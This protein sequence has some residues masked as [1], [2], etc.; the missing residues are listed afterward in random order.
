M[1]NLTN[2]TSEELA[3]EILIGERFFRFIKLSDDKLKEH[4]PQL[5]EYLKKENLSEDNLDFLG[6][7]ISW[8]NLENIYLPYTDFT[9]SNLENTSLRNSFL[10]GAEFEDAKLI[11]TD[12]RGSNIYEAVIS[13]ADLSKSIVEKI[14]QTGEAFGKDKFIY[15]I[16][17][18]FVNSPEFKGKLDEFIEFVDSK[19]NTSTTLDCN[20]IKF[21]NYNKATGYFRRA[22]GI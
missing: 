1:D 22:K 20:R 11:N 2:M 16:E 3:N 17:S 12:F 8:K 4:I 14:L 9:E 10:T 13:K 18:D 5:N 21:I 7:D 6:A 15:F 19:Y